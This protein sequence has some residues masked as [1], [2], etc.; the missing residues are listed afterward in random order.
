MNVRSLDSLIIRRIV[1]SEQAGG[2]FDQRNDSLSTE[3][4]FTVVPQVSIRID[5]AEQ[6]YRPDAEFC[7]GTS[8]SASIVRLGDRQ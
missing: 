6:R 5:A 8:A 2:N 3:N 7:A 1:E 4:A